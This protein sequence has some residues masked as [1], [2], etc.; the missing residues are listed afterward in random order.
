MRVPAS[1]VNIIRIACAMICNER[2]EMLVVRKRGTS[3]FM[4]PGGK[5][6]PGEAANVAL[7][8]ELIEEIAVVADAAEMAFLGCFSAPAVNEPGWTVEAQLFAVPYTG[9]PVA[10]AEIEAIRWVDPVAAG[11]LVLAP[12]TRDAV[13]PLCVRG[14]RQP[15]R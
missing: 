8:R 13:L 11:D 7:A 12:L 3:A 5:I 4:Q 6:E 1:Q 9:V 15:R 2:G 14:H 10:C